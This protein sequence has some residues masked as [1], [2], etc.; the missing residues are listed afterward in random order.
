[1]ESL[2]ILDELD[3]ALSRRVSPYSLEWYM[4]DASTNGGMS[5]EV[6]SRV[7]KLQRRVMLADISN[8]VARSFVSGFARLEEQGKSP[9]FL[10]DVGMAK[11]KRLTGTIGDKGP[12]AIMASLPETKS[13]IEITYRS[14]ENIKKLLPT[15]TRTLG[16]VEG[17]L[18]GISVRGYT[19]FIVYE[20]LTDK[21]VSCT[22]PKLNLLDKAKDSL[23]SRVQV[24][25]IVHRNKRGEP[26]RVVIQNPNDFK[27][28]GVDLNI[29]PLEQLGGSDPDFT[30]TL[31][32]D[33]FIRRIRD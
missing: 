13:F 3:H 9:A 22:S 28:F 21:G 16:S 24:T 31:S 5:L 33:E 14:A 29:L 7:R 32:T 11:V 15:A 6:Y 23:G 8:E 25:G 20:G 26:I 27:V 19:R 30:G 1:M 4:R 2:G 12:R 17:R 10:T 18:E